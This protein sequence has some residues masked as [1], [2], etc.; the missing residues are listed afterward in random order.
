MFPVILLQPETVSLAES[1]CAL[2]C[3]N[4][5][6]G[7][8]GQQMTHTAQEELSLSL[9]SEGL[10]LRGINYLLLVQLK[11]K[12]TRGLTRC[13]SYFFSCSVQNCMV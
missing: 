7:A 8:T 1:C 10:W 9:L 11:R 5:E 3:A 4:Q 6:A 13:W 12:G 2:M